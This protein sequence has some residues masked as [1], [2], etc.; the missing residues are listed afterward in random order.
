MDLPSIQIIEGGKAS[1]LTAEELSS[2]AV[3]VPKEVERFAGQVVVFLDELLAGRDVKDRLRCVSPRGESYILPASALAGHCLLSTNTPSWKLIPAGREQLDEITVPRFVLRAVETIE[4]G[5][6][7]AAAED[8]A[9]AGRGS[10]EVFTNL[11]D[12]LMRPAVVRFLSLTSAHLDVF[13]PGIFELVN[14]ESLNLGKNRIRDIP[15]EIGQ[16]RNLEVLKLSRNRLQTLPE[17]IGRLKR[18]VELHVSRNEI[19]TLPEKFW[20]LDRL[21]LLNLGR[22]RLTSIPDDVASL[23]SLGTLELDGNPIP[24]A[25]RDRIE[26]LVPRVTIEW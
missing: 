9:V 22:N 6:E 20:N 13:P 21:T 14:L 26:R 5:V 4:L 15:P 3:A 24:R 18:L 23:V 8:E 11:T 19:A 7:Q 16:L 10:D 1:A 17:E 25:A 2:A 12:A